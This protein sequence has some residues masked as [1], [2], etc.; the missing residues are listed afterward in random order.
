MIWNTPVEGC[1][2][3]R[4]FESDLQKAR[5][6]V[7]HDEIEEFYRDA[8]EDE[9]FET[10][11]DLLLYLEAHVPPFEGVMS[12]G[13]YCLP[14]VLIK[15]G[16]VNGFIDLGGAG[17]ADRYCDIADCYRSLKGNYWGWFDTKAYA[18]YDPEDFLRAL[19]MPIDREKLRFVLLLNN[20]L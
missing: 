4:T 18:D 9:P 2:R 8:F 5:Q 6:R 19:Q 13:D 11:M 15:D 14:N 7:E 1:P 10:P 17:I 12:H 16:K 20:L 3:V